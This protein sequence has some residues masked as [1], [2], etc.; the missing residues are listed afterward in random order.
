M[1]FTALHYQASPL[2]LANV[3]DASSARAAAQAGY[4]AL[5]TSSAAIA[6]MLGYADGESLT[7]EEL[8]F[9]VCRIRAASTLPLNVDMESGYAETPDG[10]VENLL[11]LAAL[12][13]VGVNLE[14]S[15]VRNG[16]RE[17]EDA[18]LFANRLQ[19]I[20]KGLTAQSC[21]L[22]LNIRTD[23]FLLGLAN[24]REETLT[25]TMRYAEHGADG[26][27][28]PCV[29]HPDD[30]AAIVNQT[31][32]PLNVMAVPVLPDF[33]QLGKLG[34]RRISMGNA[35]HCAIQNRL[36]ELLLTLRQ[37]QSFTGVFADENHR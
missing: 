24:A 20:R 4:Q 28:V 9:M 26:I 5:G 1:D 8:Y 30:I 33:A 17:L 36:N 37:Q 16:K 19:S 15:R 3:W 31:S 18:A 7:F 25:R 27:F 13:V 34:V 23:P 32:L 35:L 29:T 11:R 2:L 12:G 22:F 14:D 10:V 21:T 6:T